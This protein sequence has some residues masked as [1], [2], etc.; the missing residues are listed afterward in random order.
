MP[1]RLEEDLRAAFERAT[2]GAGSR[3]Q[4]TTAVRALVRKLKREEQPPEKV[5][6]AVKQACGLSLITFAADTDAN[7]D[8][9]EP[10]Q[11]ADMALRAA[12]DEYYAK[13]S[14]V[15]STSKS[16]RPSPAVE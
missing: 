5:I 12:I 10:K 7:A 4:L 14:P 15:G 1:T 9:S 6:V 16:R 3:E 11:I 8:T 13:S 2:E